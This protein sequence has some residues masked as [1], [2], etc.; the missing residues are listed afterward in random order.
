M[1][2]SNTQTEMEYKLMEYI[3]TYTGKKF[4]FNYSSLSFGVMFA[5]FDIVD[6]AHALS[7]LCRFNGHCRKFYSVA[8]HS[9]LCSLYCQK[10]PLTALLHD[11]AEAYVGDVS[12]P[13]KK[14]LN[15]E[16][17]S[18]LEDDILDDI[19]WYFGNDNDC[20]GLPDEI[21]EVDMRMLATE[22]R[23]LMFNSGD[24]ASLTGYEPYPEIIEPW[25]PKKAKRLF[26]A[27]YEE[28]RK[29]REEE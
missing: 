19:L 7:N 8:Q 14:H 18:Q 26:L 13:L 9:V 23:D 29:L 25:K 6:I 12:K 27:R 16:T 1:P 20:A 22:K 11:A 3:Q 28:L 4:S 24:W 5:N 10:Y 21:K 17:F 15:S 2:S